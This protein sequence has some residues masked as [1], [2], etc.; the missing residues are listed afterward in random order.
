MV[1]G[2]GDVIL[3]DRGFIDRFT[4]TLDHGQ[5]VIVEL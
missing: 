2:M 5:R 1:M 4:V 3:L